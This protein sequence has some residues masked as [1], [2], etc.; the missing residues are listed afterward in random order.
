MPEVNCYNCGT[1][2]GT[3]TGN[4]LNYQGRTILRD[5]ASFGCEVCGVIITWEPSKATR[6]ADEFE[7]TGNLV[8]KNKRTGATVQLPPIK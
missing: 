7:L 3:E 5:A 8:Q 2:I 6:K 4:K 1:F